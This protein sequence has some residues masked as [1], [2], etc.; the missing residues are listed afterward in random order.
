MGKLTIS[1]AIFNSKLLNYQRV[2]LSFTP[3]FLQVIGLFYRKAMATTSL[4]YP[5]TW[6]QIGKS[7]I[8]VL[9]KRRGTTKIPRK[10][11]SLA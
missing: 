11:R 1:M 4:G 5:Q 3:V 8:Y 9:Q 7:P 10:N 2:R 6:L